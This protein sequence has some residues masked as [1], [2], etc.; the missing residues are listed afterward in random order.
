MSAA[1]TSLIGAGGSAT[2]VGML[3]VGFK[4]SWFGAAMV[5][6]GRSFKAFIDFSGRRRATR[7]VLFVAMVLTFDRRKAVERPHI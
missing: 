4:F 1:I 2:V 3:N 6:R 7:K 5:V